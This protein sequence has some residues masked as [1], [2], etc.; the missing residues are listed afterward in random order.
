MLEAAGFS[1][2][3]ADATPAATKAA[4]VVLKNPGGRGAV[5]EFIET[6][7]RPERAKASRRRPLG[8]SRIR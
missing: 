6:G 2:C 7:A 1:A 5:R 4:K 3:P 8:R